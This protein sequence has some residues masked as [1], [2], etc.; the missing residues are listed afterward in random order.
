MASLITLSNYVIEDS[1]INLQINHGMYLYLS[2]KS[3]I[4]KFMQQIA[5]LESAQRKFESSLFDIQKICQADLFDSELD[6]AT[7]LNKKGFVRG[8]GAIAGV[9]LE[10]HLK[11]VCKNHKIAIQEKNPTINFLNDL[12]KKKQVI[13]I[14]KHRHIQL[15]AD[16]RNLCD[17]D[18]KTEPSKKDIV[19]LIEGVN[20][21]TKSLF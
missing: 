8:A 17:H 5:I 2:P 6:A 14:P 18:K 11:Q 15:L 13:D 3:A 19:K 21:I 7:E 4:P 20:E 9:V 1:L 16:W 10:R 12:L